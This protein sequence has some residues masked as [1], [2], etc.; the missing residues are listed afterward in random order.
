MRDAL[1]GMRTPLEAL[2]LRRR[3]LSA[4]PTMAPE[5]RA[6][7][8]QSETA[9][10]LQAAAFIVVGYA[11]YTV[12]VQVVVD[13]PRPKRR[14]HPATSATDEPPAPAPVATATAEPTATAAPTAAPAPAGKSC[15]DMYVDCRSKGAPC[16]RKL[17][18]KTMCAYCQDNCLADEPY[19]FKQCT[20]CGYQ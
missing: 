8:G 5:A 6:L 9:L 12:I 3:P 11:V 20:E 2:A 4:D 1:Y 7:F 13:K 10:F 16:D 14:P 18:G 15:T 17:G 19:K